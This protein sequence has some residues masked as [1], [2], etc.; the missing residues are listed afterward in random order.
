MDKEKK[1]SERIDKIVIALM[2]LAAAL[3][4][5]VVGG[6]ILWMQGVNLGLEWN[7]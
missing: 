3:L 7:Y 5:F 2:P 1:R 4:A 6:I